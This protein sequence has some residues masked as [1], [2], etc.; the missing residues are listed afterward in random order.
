MWY[1]LIFRSCENFRAFTVDWVQRTAIWYWNWKFNAHPPRLHKSIEEILTMQRI[2]Y[3]RVNYELPTIWLCTWE[4]LSTW[5]LRR[6]REAQVKIKTFAS[7]K[8][9][10]IEP[11]TVPQRCFIFHRLACVPLSIA[12]CLYRRDG[13]LSYC[14][15]LAQTTSSDRSDWY[16]VRQCLNLTLEHV[17]SDVMSSQ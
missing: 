17:Q 9:K 3:R 4:S 12:E 15:V 16:R 2:H 5:C 13:Q 7:Q 6:N 8:H 11:S 14:K 10:T 1:D